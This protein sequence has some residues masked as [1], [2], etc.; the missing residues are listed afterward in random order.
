MSKYL[1]ICSL[2]GNAYS[3]YHLK[4]K[5]KEIERVKSY[6]YIGVPNNDQWDASKEIDGEICVFQIQHH[7]N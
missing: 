1:N 4:I 7:S 2:A 3:N 6:K 5:T